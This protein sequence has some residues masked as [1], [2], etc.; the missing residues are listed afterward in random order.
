MRNLVRIRKMLSAMSIR[1][2][3]AIKIFLFSIVTIS[4]II[5]LASPGT[6]G[7]NHPADDLDTDIEWVSSG[8]TTVQWGK[9]AEIEIGDVPYL[10]KAHDFS[11]TD[12]AAAISVARKDGGITKSAILYI[13]RGD[14][15]WMH[16][17]HEIK[18]ELTGVSRDS[19]EV[20]SA[21]LNYYVRGNPELEID[22]TASSETFD[23]IEVSS[24]Q[25]APKKEKK[26]TIDV[27]NTGEAWVENIDLEIDIGQLGIREKNDLE[28]H[29]QTLSTNLG[30][31][32]VNDKASVNFTIVA[33]EW[34]GVTS[35]YEI[36]YDIIATANGV[37]IK[38]RM[39]EANASKTLSCTDPELNVVRKIYSEELYMSTWRAPLQSN[40]YD[41]KYSVIR[42]E[43]YNTGFYAM[44]DVKVVD[45]TLPDGL[46]ITETY[47]E[48]TP[49]YI[50]SNDPYVIG[51][52][53]FPLKPGTYKIDK[54]TVT[55]NFYGKE[56][57]WDAEGF[58]IE[59]NGPHI[60]LKKTIQQ[61]GNGNYR[62]TLTMQNTGD[63][64]LRHIS[65]ILHP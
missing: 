41:D 42:S 3:D 2:N 34:D 36:S 55:S 29:G 10:L 15:S 32:D 12:D 4:A 52:K 21:K 16:Y 26:I 14:D 57:K 60:T 50:S 28:Y 38:G 9:V 24:D 61:E 53:L 18:I 31:L 44:T 35:P 6:A 13:N 58:T 23:D 20:P 45:F 30:Y 48:G 22:I 59:V 25:Y 51:Y 8:S 56:F 27:T 19:Y 17:D 11:S 62:V 49:S 46:Y 43:V 33:P 7:T 5:L 64:G 47:E 54:V 1:R 37:D 65:G 63:R 40:V 39:Y